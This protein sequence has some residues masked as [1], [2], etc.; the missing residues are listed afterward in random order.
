MCFSR[1]FQWATS[2]PLGEMAW[3]SR[4]AYLGP[5][6]I[7]LSLVR[8]FFSLLYYLNGQ[9]R[10]VSYKKITVVYCS[11]FVFIPLPPQIVFYFQKP[12][13]SVFFLSNS[14][15]IDIGVGGLQGGWLGL[16]LRS[17]GPAAEKHRDDVFPG[18]ECWAMTGLESHRTHLLNPAAVWPSRMQPDMCGTFPAPGILYQGLYQAPGKQKKK[19]KRERGQVVRGNHSDKYYPSYLS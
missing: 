16:S 5:N 13:T 11:L 14:L 7:N 9:L 10:A 15:W 12:C 2:Y 1:S 19:K 18:P 6:S 8:H 3:H 17:I 4:R